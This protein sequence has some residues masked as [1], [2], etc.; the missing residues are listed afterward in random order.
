MFRDL[1][2]L[3][4]TIVGINVILKSLHYQVVYYKINKSLD[5]YVPYKNV[6]PE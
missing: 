3:V 6:K 5:H 4:F 1:E 2:L